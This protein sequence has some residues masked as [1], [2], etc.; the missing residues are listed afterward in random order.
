MA[1]ALKVWHRVH[2]VF[3][4][5]SPPATVGGAGICSATGIWCS[6]RRWATSAQSSSVPYMINSVSCLTC[7][8][9]SG[10]P[11]ERAHGGIE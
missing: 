7:H 9:E 10:P 6:S 11:S 1:P 3:A 4:T 5:S 8:G 2:T